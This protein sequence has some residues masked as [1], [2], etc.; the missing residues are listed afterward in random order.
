M[1][2]NAASTEFHQTVIPFFLLFATPDR[3]RGCFLLAAISVSAG[4]S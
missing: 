3:I 2:K 4:V 1:A